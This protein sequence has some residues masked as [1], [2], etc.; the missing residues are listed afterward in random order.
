MHLQTSFTSHACLHIPVYLLHPGHIL[1]LNRSCFAGTVTTRNCQQNKRSLVITLYSYLEKKKRK[2]CMG[3]IALRID[4]ERY[5]STCMQRCSSHVQRKAIFI[6]K[7]I[8]CMYYFSNQLDPYTSI[9]FFIHY[10]SKSLQMY[11]VFPIQ[12]FVNNKKLKKLL[13]LSRVS[14]SLDAV[15]ML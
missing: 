10:I 4:I 1:H 14:S 8:T 12:S 9:I 6:G 11:S 2:I 13:S 3:P 7:K 5:T 15:V